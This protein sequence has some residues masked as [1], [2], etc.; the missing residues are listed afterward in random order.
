MKQVKT[1]RPAPKGATT[2][3][4]SFDAGVAALGEERYAE[5]ISIFSARLLANPAELSSRANRAIALWES[6][7][8][9]EAIR[10]FEEVVSD[11]R[12]KPDAEFHSLG[13][14]YLNLGR[15]A[16]A[17]DAYRRFFE[18]ATRRHPFYWAALHCLA[19]AVQKLGQASLA[20]DLMLEVVRLVPSEENYLALATLYSS[21]GRRPETLAVL[22][23][24]ESLGVAGRE[25]R[26]LGAPVRREL[27]RREGRRTPEA[28]AKIEWERPLMKAK[29][30]AALCARVLEQQAPSASV[31][32]T[33]GLERRT[34]QDGGDGTAAAMDRDRPRL[35]DVFDVRSAAVVLIQDVW[36]G[37]GPAAPIAARYELRR[38]RGGGLS[39]EG[40][41][42]TG[43]TRK[44][45]RVR[46]AMKAATASAFLDALAGASLGPGPYTSF[47]DHTDD[48]PRIEI[49]VEVPTRKIGDQ[50]GIA[51]LYTASQGEFHTPWAAFVGGR[52]YVIAGDEVGRALRALD[53]PLKKQDLQRM[54]EGD[55][56]PRGPVS[57]DERPALQGSCV[58]SHAFGD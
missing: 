18:R 50:S 21:E 9:E 53:H 37:Y 10:A 27:G 5:A 44:P 14:S 20:C 28:L 47:W 45:K 38:S 16:D 4:P 25:L 15:Y 57:H 1:R 54:S 31:G 7:R 19:L 11:P 42:S 39:G 46:V 56:Q 40:E 51:L 55:R 8:W 32:P 3:V 29:Q 6:L 35:G 26:A 49:V 52:A 30:I 43:L 48:S 33:T 17:V 34:T 12:S 36:V 41:L 58:A 23:R 24:A 2:G 13:H 22:H